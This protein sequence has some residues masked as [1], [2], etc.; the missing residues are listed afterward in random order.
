V[1][2]VILVKPRVK[3]IGEWILRFRDEVAVE[4]E[5]VVL[6]GEDGRVATRNGTR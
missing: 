1:I 5:C 4:V 3:A 6:R 2:V